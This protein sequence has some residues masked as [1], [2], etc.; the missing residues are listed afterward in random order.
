[1]KKSKLYITTLLTS[2]ALF[3]TA[4]D[5]NEPDFF[6]S[7][8]NGA[9][10]GYENASDFEY[11]LNFA[12]YIIGKPKEAPVIVSINLLGYLS[13]AQRSLSIK[14]KK[15][16]GFGV[17]KVTIPEVVFSNNEYKKEISI[18]VERPEV[19]DSTFAI[20]LYLDGTGD[21]GTGING[22]DEFIIYVKEVYEAP[23]FWNRVSYYLGNWN[24]DKHMFL[25]STLN[26]NK[27]HE[28]FIRDSQL[29][30]DAV[31]EANRVA[32]DT[33]LAKEQDIP[34]YIDIPILEETEKIDYAE[35]FFWKDCKAYLGEFKGKK[36]SIFAKDIL[37][38]ANT[39]N[40][41]AR[42]A[43][44]GTIDKIKEKEKDFNINDVYDMLLEYHS[45]ASSGYPISEY[46]ERCWVEIKRKNI[47]AYKVLTPYWWEDPNKLGTANIVKSYFGEY[48]DEKYRFMMNKMI[49]ALS[50]EN[51]V[52]AEMFPFIL[53]K[54]KNSF[55]WD[56]IERDG[57][58]VNGEDYIK[59]CY[60]IIK[61]GYDSASKG[62]KD[63]FSFP[64][65]NL[66]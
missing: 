2:L 34:E 22:K 30:T 48:S 21:L 51:F 14:T 7:T 60:K 31:K 29:D 3:F 53:N 61:S 64:E 33:L 66:E 56:N 12:D 28:T 23:L 44:A 27:Y 42:Y 47:N 63:M 26:N 35:P 6:D 57:N 11:T 38:G 65:L 19:E 8:A 1:M 32:V 18:M 45:Y 37:S 36:L 52:V 59:E 9:Y 62:I 50:S 41:M 46:K 20:C 5:K 13:D 49:E 40:F 39:A 15:V 58:I 4:C 10:F 16:E 17:A 43:D 24:K 55:T 54:E 25:A